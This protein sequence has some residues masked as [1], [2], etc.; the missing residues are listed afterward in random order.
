MVLDFKLVLRVLKG[1]FYSLIFVLMHS[2]NFLSYPE[3]IFSQHIMQW[4]HQPSLLQTQ[5]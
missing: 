1:L 5:V 4:L 3:I 2:I